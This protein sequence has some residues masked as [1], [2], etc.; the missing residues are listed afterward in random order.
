[1]PLP[2][3]TPACVCA[4]D[5][6]D[7]LC[8]PRCDYQCLPPGKTDSYSFCCLSLLHQHCL[9]ISCYRF[10]AAISRISPV[11]LNVG[12]RGFHCS[13][14]IIPYEGS[15]F[16]FHW[17]LLWEW[18]KTLDLFPSVLF[19]PGLLVGLYVFSLKLI[20]KLFLFVV[21]L[22]C[23]LYTLICSLGALDGF[24]SLGLSPWCPWVHSRPQGLIQWVPFTEG[25]PGLRML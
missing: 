19:S 25:S 18:T 17:A 14:I 23:V 13:Y 5:C 10:L 1:M 8:D 11:F 6:R 9:R 2:T 15:H 21:E 16:G 12:G 3:C 24:L 4:F 22:L 7:L 20:C